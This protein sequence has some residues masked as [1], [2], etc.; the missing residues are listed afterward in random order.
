MA[1]SLANMLARVK[2]IVP[3]TVLDTELQDAI[4]ERMNYLATLDVFP[5]QEGF[6]S[7]TL[8]S[9][10]TSMA[11]PDNFAAQKSLVLYT[12]DSQRPLTYLDPPTFDQMFPNPSDNDAEKP[13]YY[14][15]KVAEGNYYFNCPSDAAYTIYSYFHKIPDDATDTTVSQLTEMA[16]LTLIDWAASDG[17]R[18]LKEF[19]RADKLE[20]DGD[21]KLMMLRRRYQ[22]SRE[23]DAR[24]IS[25]KEFHKT[26]KAY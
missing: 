4:L 17:F 16:K 15:I 14:T 26:Q 7:A 11:T 25:L 12:A 3:T 21:K 23:Q 22:L 19:D 10:D 2:R 1:L 8:S 13:T 9:G 6:Q 24:F 20:R 18:M 5:F